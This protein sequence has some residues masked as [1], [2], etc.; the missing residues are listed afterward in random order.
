MESR[1]PSSATGSSAST[2]QRWICSDGDQIDLSSDGEVRQVHCMHVSRIDGVP[3]PGA[4]SRKQKPYKP[5]IVL[6]QPPEAVRKA[7]S[8][9]IGFIIRIYGLRLDWAHYGPEPFNCPRFV[10]EEQHFLNSILN[11]LYLFI[12]HNGIGL[13]CVA[14]VNNGIE[15]TEN[16]ISGGQYSVS[17]KLPTKEGSITCV[18][19]CTLTTGRHYQLHCVLEVTC[20]VIGPLPPGTAEIKYELTGDVADRSGLFEVG[21]YSLLKCFDELLFRGRAQREEPCVESIAKFRTMTNRKVP[22]FDIQALKEATTQI[23]SILNLPVDNNSITFTIDGDNTFEMTFKLENNETTESIFVQFNTVH[24]GLH[25]MRAYQGNRTKQ[26]SLC[27]SDSFPYNTIALDGQLSVRCKGGLQ[28][29]RLPFPVEDASGRIAY[30]QKVLKARGF[31]C[32]EMTVKDL[33]NMCGTG[34]PNQVQLILQEHKWCNQLAFVQQNKNLLMDTIE[35]V[36]RTASLLAS[37]QA[38]SVEMAQTSMKMTEFPHTEPERGLTFISEHSKP[39]F[40]CC[41]D[42]DS[43]GNIALNLSTQERVIMSRIGRPLGGIR[44]AHGARIQATNAASKEEVQSTN[45]D[46]EEEDVDESEDDPRADSDEDENEDEDGVL[47]HSCTFILL[48]AIS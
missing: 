8:D 46:S 24:E 19:K 22:R 37:A 20:K 3:I 26:I 4:Y 13:D 27:R 30:F 44:L 48:R 6:S 17:V 33:L 25:Q 28:H 11:V 31:V 39:P 10:D 21:Y 14:I 45:G 41:I 47:V 29:L 43:A 18:C 16:Q 40:Y 9:G 5:D 35:D 36:I 23:C 42:L 12:S 2:L 32:T 34:G 1:S 7:I 15:C 38:R